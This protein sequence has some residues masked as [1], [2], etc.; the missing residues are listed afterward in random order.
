MQLYSVQ[1][2]YKIQNPF[3]IL[4]TVQNENMKLSVLQFWWNQNTRNVKKIQFWGTFW[5][6]LFGMAV[7][8]AAI[9]AI[10]FFEMF[11]N[12]HGLFV[13][14]TISTIIL[15]PKNKQTLEWLSKQK[16]GSKRATI[17]SGGSW[18]KLIK[19]PSRTSFNEKEFN[20]VCL[21]FKWR[22]FEFSLTSFRTQKRSS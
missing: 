4:P 16:G 11:G 8:S 19:T 21:F 10:N 7:C 17:Q 22:G 9:I 15:K 5:Y 13:L 12:L 14:R 6:V 1:Y 20:I 18:K 2:H 3:P